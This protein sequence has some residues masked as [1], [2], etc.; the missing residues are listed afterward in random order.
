[1]ETEVAFV[2]LPMGHAHCATQQCFKHPG[3]PL[4]P[5]SLAPGTDRAGMCVRVTSPTHTADE[6]QLCLL[7]LCP[8]P[9]F[10]LHPAASPLRQLAEG[11]SACR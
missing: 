10:P 9:A 1:M 2:T 7:P 6:K 5:S 4:W 3:M 11:S 8:L